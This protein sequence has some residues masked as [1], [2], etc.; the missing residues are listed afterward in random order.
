MEASKVEMVCRGAAAA[1]KA[2]RAVSA[3]QLDIRYQ[4]NGVCITRLL[5]GRCRRMDSTR[6]DS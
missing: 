6:P 2:A 3:N 4:G 5:N 1:L